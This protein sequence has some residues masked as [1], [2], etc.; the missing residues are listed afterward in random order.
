MSVSLSTDPNPLA[1]DEQ[2]VLR[3]GGTRVTFDTVI[4][5]YLDGATVE[6]IVIRYDS[7]QLADVHATIA[8][9]L[10]HQT[11]LEHYLE[12]RRT[13]SQQVREQVDQRQGVQNIRT[14]LASRVKNQG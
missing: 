2:G 12:K 4:S 8:Y 7:L 13:Q 3:V 11:E 9:F 6:E 5:A 10:R 14:K 1:L